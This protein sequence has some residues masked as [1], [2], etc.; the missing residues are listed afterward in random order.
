MITIYT[1]TVLLAL[2]F[3]AFFTASE[4]SFTSLSRIKLKSLVE[5]KDPRALRL[6]EFLSKKGM[7]L[8]TTLVGTNIAVIV[9]S[10]LTTRIFAEHFDTNVS[11]VLTTVVLVPVTLIFAEIVPKLI[12]RQFATSMA[13]RNVTPLN[14]FRR[15]FSP[16]IFAVTSISKLLLLPFGKP[17]TPW[18]VTFTKRDL[19]RLVVSGREAGEMEADEVELIHKVLDFG[20]KS[21]DNIMVPL[22]RVSSIAS[23]DTARNLK[24]LVS[25]TGY[26]RIPVYKKNK[27]DIIGIINIYDVLFAAEGAEKAGLEDFIREPVHLK[28]TDGLDIALKRLRYKKQPMGIVTDEEQQVVGIVTIEDILE[29][30]VGE[31]EDRG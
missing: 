30:I 22:Y 18:D 26:S 9:A 4:M 20:A 14:N 25:L 12:G 21:V 10:T 29:E 28:K 23:D 15:I 16:I 24:N 11:A 6:N 1:I 31:I 27:S 17:P 2:I 8:G 19:K 7:F 13:L 3:Q 5:A